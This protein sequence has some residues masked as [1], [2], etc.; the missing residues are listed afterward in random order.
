MF[1]QDKKAWKAK[2]EKKIREILANPEQIVAAI[3]SRQSVQTKGGQMILKS[4]NKNHEFLSAEQLPQLYQDLDNPHE[5][6]HFEFSGTNKD[7]IEHTV[8]KHIHTENLEVSTSKR[9][10]YDAAH[11]QAYSHLLINEGLQ[12]TQAEEITD[13]PD[14]VDELADNFKQFEAELQKIAANILL[15]ELTNQQK[16]QNDTPKKPGFFGRIFNAI[17]NALASLANTVKNLLGLGTPTN[18]TTTPDE[19]TP[20]R[21]STDATTQSSDSSLSQGTSI[22]SDSTPISALST[23]EREPLD[24]RKTTTPDEQTPVRRSTDAT[25][26]SSDSTLSQGTSIQSDLTT[27]SASS[28]SESEPLDERKKV[29]EKFGKLGQQHE[30]ALEAQS[31]S[32]IEKTPEA[33]PEPEKP[34]LKTH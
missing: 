30:A 27:I 3:A 15:N 7:R 18:Q 2:Y 22:Q 8:T 25:T 31:K 11:W 9:F 20:V 6:A 21:R 23:S 14:K 16:L 32:T 1:E 34:T 29:Q 12:A 5:S 4:T 28:I 19:E 26:Q 17:Q 33:T 13:N 10:L 24:E